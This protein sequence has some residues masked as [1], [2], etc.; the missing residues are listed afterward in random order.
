MPASVDIQAKD[1]LEVVER[2]IEQARG[3]PAEWYFGD[4]H[5]KREQ[6]RLFRTNWFAV[7]F[8]EDVANSGDAFPAS[9]CGS[10][11]VIV[12]DADGMARAFHNVCRHRA[13]LVVLKP[14]KGLHSLK[15]IYHCWTYG[16]DGKLKNAPFFNGKPSCNAG[17]GDDV[18]LVPVRCAEREG[19]IFVNLSGDAQDIDAYLEPLTSRWQQFD[20]E[21]LETFDT[22]EKSIPANW[23]VVYEGL[24][25]VYHEEFIH[26]DL[27]YRLTEDG[28]KAFEDVWSGELMGFS[29]VMPE[30]VDDHP[31]IALKRL[32]GMPATGKAPTEIFLIFPN[33]SV[34]ILD[35]HLVRTIW[36]PVS[37]DETRW[38]SSWYF[39]PGTSDTDSGRRLGNDVIAFWEKVRS[40]DL[41]AVISVQ[42]G[43][44]S[45]TG[46]AIATRYSPFW[47]PILQ[48]FHA[49]VAVGL[50]EE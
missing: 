43:L 40:E 7:C 12:R 34:N 31:E 19:V 39:A 32:P 18:S 48:H 16:L 5:F 33:L 9:V 49:R 22:R 50:V 14:E 10:E 11:L 47:E 46:A 6:D 25:E 38:R 15:C 17:G 27:G 36:T 21:S 45:Q 3:L 13:S 4:D 24:L 42:A 35:N 30:D 28:D 8:S 2:P 37:P 20:R 23:K 44:K 1:V 26:E 41:R 29:S